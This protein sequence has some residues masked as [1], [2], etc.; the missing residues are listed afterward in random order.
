MAATAAAKTMGRIS[1]GSV[2]ALLRAG[3]LGAARAVTEAAVIPATLSSPLASNEAAEV[4]YS[5]R[6]MATCSGDVSVMP[7]LSAGFALDFGGRRGLVAQSSAQP[8]PSST[9]FSATR[10]FSGGGDK[11]GE[12]THSDFAPEY[13]SGDNL[14]SVSSVI[15]K[16]VSAHKVFVYMKGVPA[17]PQCGFS[18]MVCRILDAYQVE[19]GSRNVL[20]DPE[21]RQ[22]I[23]DY[24][25]WPTIPQIFI[26]GDFVGGCDILMEMHKSGDLEEMFTEAS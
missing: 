3:T 15:E 22:G 20:E 7:R 21:I 1:V 19:Y 26:D 16:D 17:A 11:E 10:K 9:C 12:G 24:T 13:K 23:K 18:N 6:F 4:T 5:R 14:E 25:Q 2:G 8:W